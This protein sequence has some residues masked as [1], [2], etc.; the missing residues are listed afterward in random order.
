MADT[1]K[2]LYQ[3]QLPATPTTLYTVP[4][5]TQTIVRH[6]RATNPNASN[7]TMRLWQNG[8]NASNEILPTATVLASGWAEF[9]GTILMFAADTLAGESDSAAKITLSIYG[10]E[11]A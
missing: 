7:Y 6:M 8:S 3:G 5:A 2:M 11:V 1:F 10:D 4:A 9:D